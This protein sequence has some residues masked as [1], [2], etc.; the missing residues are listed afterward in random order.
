[1]YLPNFVIIGA[2]KCGTTSI[3]YYLKQHPQVYLPNRKELH[4]F[5]YE[6][7]ARNSYGPGDKSTLLA[8]C[9]TSEQYREYYSSVGSQKAIGEVSPSYLYYAETA[10]RIKEEVGDVKI[11]AILRNPK[12]K[13]FSQYM[14]LVREN[15]ETLSFYDALMIEEERRKQ[16]WSDIW[17]YAESTLYSEKIKKFQNVFGTSNV[18]VLFFEDFISSPKESMREVFKFINVDEKHSVD[19]DKQYNRTGISR[20]K[21]VTKF[22]LKDNKL[23]SLGKA[24]IPEDFRVRL[25]LKL[26]DLNTGKKKQIDKQSEE[27][28]RGYFD[29]DIRRLDKIKKV[30]SSWHRH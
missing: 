27:Y 12:E 5:S 29:D 20:S 10:E 24:M 14:H 17:S 13:A 15:R 8:L 9:S 23:K 16:G 30:P 19:T 4:Y 26:L 25:R 22:F 1:M 7:L 28:L 2:P 11:I 18:M 3:F 6:Q 21:I